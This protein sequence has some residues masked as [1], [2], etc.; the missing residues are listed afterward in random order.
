MEEAGTG[1]HF[2]WLLL[3]KANQRIISVVA[4]R[5]HIQPHRLITN[6]VDY[7]NNIVASI[8]LELVEICDEP[9]MPIEEQ[10]TQG[11]NRLSQIAPLQEKR[12]NSPESFPLL[13]FSCKA[14]L[15]M[16]NC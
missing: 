9:L 2:D 6:L 13:A 7:G 10:L 11:E 3:H 15:F 12:N 1:S 5:L 14:T 16:A 4:N 8:P